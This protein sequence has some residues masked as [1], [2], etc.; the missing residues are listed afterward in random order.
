M[1]QVIQVRGRSDDRQE[2]QPTV[3]EQVLQ[4]LQIAQGVYGIKTKYDENQRTARKD[5]GEMTPVEIADLEKTHEVGV[6]APQGVRATTIKNTEDGSVMQAW[7]RRQKE[8]VKTQLL[9]SRQ[10]DGSEKLEIVEDKPGV[11]RTSA[12][13]VK[14]PGSLQ[15][16]QLQDENT[17]E[18]FLGGLDP[19]SGQ[20]RQRY[21]VQD[22]KS[23]DLAQKAKEAEAKAKE[24]ETGLL[25]PMYGAPARME[26]EAKVFRKDAANAQSAAALL[27]QIKEI[28]TDISLNERTKIARIKTAQSMAMGMLREPILGPGTLSDSDKELLMDALG[29]PSALFSAEGVQKA[30]IDTAIE[31]IQRGLDNRAAQS[32]VFPAGMTPQKAREEAAMTPA[33][34]DMRERAKALLKSRGVITDGGQ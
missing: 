12:P 34:R 25:V 10:A 24:R 28:G 7:V 5:A 20:L 1:A 30:K 2:R 19:K 33:Q 9:R 13:E 6:E 31:V 27:N 17:G 21:K 16:H 29:D 11:V 3:M 22:V 8:P 15:W 4:G 18:V 23:M 26:E 14:D 32:L